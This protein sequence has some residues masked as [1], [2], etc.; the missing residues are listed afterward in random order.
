[1]NIKSR[2]KV[3]M[4]EHESIALISSKMARAKLLA[5][6]NELSWV[7]GQLNKETETT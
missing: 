6:A 4:R 7:L 3:R 1:M 2:I 5:R